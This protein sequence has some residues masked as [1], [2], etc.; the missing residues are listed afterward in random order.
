MHHRGMGFE[1]FKCGHGVMMS[2][3]LKNN[4][5]QAFF[6]RV[7]WC[8]CRM[9][10]SFLAVKTVLTVGLKLQQKMTCFKSQWEA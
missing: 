7:R 3:S 2:I 8:Y 5:I 6:M 1:I 9:N 10:S 4:S